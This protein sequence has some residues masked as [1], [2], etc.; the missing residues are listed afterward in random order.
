MT[1]SRT[2]L[3]ALFV[4]LL[5]IAW[6]AR[7]ADAADPVLVRVREAVLD[8]SGSAR[9]VVGISGADRSLSA[10]DFSVREGG[11]PIAAVSATPLAE[12]GADAVSVVLAIDV[13]GST[14]GE[15]LAD[16]KAAAK[17]FLAGLHPRVRVA[18]VAFGAD[19]TLKSPFTQDRARLGRLIDALQA[20]GDTTLYD[21]V[22]LASQQFG[23]TEAASSI[24]V[25]SDG[26]DTG[27]AASLGRALDLA[28]RAGA[29]VT[30]IALQTRDVDLDA[31]RALAQATGGRL[32]RVNQSG[33]LQSAF[34][35][36]A[37]D[38]ASQYVLSYSVQGRRE[39]DV[40]IAVT[41]R[42]AGRSAEDSIVA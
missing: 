17:A 16:A 28:K 31:L 34:T 8:P 12:A 2:A 7:A 1:R 32:L 30:S 22:V 29:P 24:I 14:A 23:R 36:A 35:S 25:F 6:P 20:K 11:R 18:L 3:C 39:G 5:C 27:S 21:A 42:I 19:A 10:G 15:P 38:I 9:V 13:S 4:T 40:E 26:K 37:R 41:A 33:D